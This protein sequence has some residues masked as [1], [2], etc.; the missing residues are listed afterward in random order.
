[1]YR[2]RAAR[3]S[4]LTSTSVTPSMDLRAFF[5]LA[6]H[7][8]QTIPSTGIVTILVCCWDVGCACP[9][10]ARTNRLTPTTTVSKT[11]AA[12]TNHLIGSYLPLSPAPREIGRAH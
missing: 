2:T 8:A 1:M 11:T 5:T 6:V 3:R 7:D 9:C 4:R 10:L 12:K